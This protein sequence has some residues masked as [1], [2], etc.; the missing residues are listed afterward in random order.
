MRPGHAE[1]QHREGDVHQQAPLLGS[2][3]AVRL[4]VNHVA[5]GNPIAC[6]FHFPN[7]PF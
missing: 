4:S 7:S 5:G 6:Q 1:F 2:A 3:D